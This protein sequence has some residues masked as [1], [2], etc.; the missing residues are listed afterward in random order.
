MKKVVISLGRSLLKPNEAE[1]FVISASHEAVPRDDRHQWL[2]S[3]IFSAF[4]CNE[5]AQQ[6][7]TKSEYFVTFVATREPL[8]GLAQLPG[9]LQNLAWR[10][11]GT[12]NI[13]IFSHATLEDTQFDHLRKEENL[14]SLE[15]W[16]ICDEKIISRKPPEFFLSDSIIPPG[17]KLIKSITTPNDLIHVADE[18]QGNFD[19][20]WL[21]GQL[22][23]KKSLHSLENLYDHLAADF[24]RA[25]DL[26]ECLYQ[27]DVASAPEKQLEGKPILI[28]RRINKI[29]DRLIQTNSSLAYVV[30][31]T[32]NGSNPIGQDSCLVANHSLLGIG[33]A[34]RGVQNFTDFISD[35]FQT[36]SV[37]NVIDHSYDDLTILAYEQKKG[38]VTPSRKVIDQKIT[39][40]NSSKEK[41]LSKLAYFSS[42]LGFKEFQNSITVAIQCLHAC[43]S[44]RWT[45]MT[46]TH[47]LLHAHIR[48]I[49]ATILSPSPEELPEDA[50]LRFAGEHLDNLDHKR[51]RDLCN[52][53]VTKYLRYSIFE[54]SDY[55]YENFQASPQQKSAQIGGALSTEGQLLRLK[56]AFPLIN[57]IMVHALD[58]PYF[59]NDDVPQYLRSLWD[60]W[61]TIPGV[62]DRLDSYLIR[63]LISVGSFKE[64]DQHFELLTHAKSHIDLGFSIDTSFQSACKEVI[65]AIED[66]QT[67]GRKSA[68]LD[69]ILERL[70]NPHSRKN[71]RL[72]YFACLK[73]ALI[74]REF[75]LSETI[76][77]HF[78]SIPD[79]YADFDDEKGEIYKI[80]T[81]DL[82][83]S[84]IAN[85]LR[86]LQ[87]RLRRGI[88]DISGANQIEE[89]NSAWVLHALASI[90]LKE[91]KER[92]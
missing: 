24:N 61:S 82:V 5:E 70:S 71:L 81:N 91:Q 21:R 32:H 40:L 17:P 22:Y 4:K 88:A 55:Y 39:A 59:Y 36:Y 43:D 83:D 20:L 66:L 25:G 10:S 48:V 62:V 77:S 31:Q 6:Y 69:L 92:T 49:L 1:R 60:S 34:I 79:K 51:S 75:F 33:T 28:Q 41:Q 53:S 90:R 47:E 80:D 63:S 52:F 37:I 38:E 2:S 42:R 67:I 16:H 23:N 9:Q 78:S 35:A 87:D 14:L 13:L 11:L 46:L 64:K 68:I 12:C 30:S 54:F 45:L 29:V 44:S 86:F 19:Y 65:G 3:P 76:R 27:G 84:F 57:E 74:T 89:W 26:V 58:L 18:L 8:P 50:A 72:H 7:L 73:L 15:Q 56:A 85:P